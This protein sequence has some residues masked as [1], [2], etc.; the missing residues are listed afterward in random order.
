[1]FKFL[2]SK[3]ESPYSE[4][5]KYGGH[6]STIDNDCSTCRWRSSIKPT[7]CEA[8]PEGIP[9]IIL[10][11]LDH[12]VPFGDED[13]T[14]EP[15]TE[16]VKKNEIENFEELHPRYPKGGPKGG[17]FMPKGSPEYEKARRES[18]ER[19]SAAKYVVGR[20][21]TDAERSDYHDKMNSTKLKE[22]YLLAQKILSP[23]TFEEF[24]KAIDSIEQDRRD[25][26]ET[27][28]QFTTSIN[29]KT[30]EGTYTPE[31]NKIH[32]KIIKKLL[33][34]ASNCKP[35][36]GKSPEYVMLGGSGGA[37][38]SSFGKGSSKVYDVA[39]HIKLDNDDIKAM[40]PGFTPEKAFL[41]HREAGDILEKAIGIAQK[42]GLNIVVDATMR[43]SVKDEIQRAKD[44]GYSIHA[45]FMHV[46]PKEAAG[47]AIYRWL[48]LKDKK[49][50]YDKNGKII[51]GRLVPPA[52]ILG[53]VENTKHFDE[54]RR[55]A[56]V[57]SFNRNN[58][59]SGVA[60]IKVISNS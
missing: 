9:M 18:L 3:E 50:Q 27:I 15:F 10:L 41:F 32:A 26:K 47:R 8:F 42:A 45:H 60:P 44:K 17:K 7:V 16:V 33:K 28:K 13:L 51:R 24:T 5:D 1:M 4:E 49:P 57:W 35:I 38:K 58:V 52:V 23:E 39:T 29:P 22:G 53:M 34:N 40:L 2:L 25:G 59:P 55:M 37:G 48:N 12:S 46:P 43:L 36:G 31:R 30:G 14:Y 6:A 21:V 11:G 54:A 20:S 56:D 19:F